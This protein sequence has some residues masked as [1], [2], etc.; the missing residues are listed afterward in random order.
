MSPW[1]WCTQVCASNFCLETPPTAVFLFYRL[2][3]HLS[4]AVPQSRYR[5]RTRSNAGG[6]EPTNCRSTLTHTLPLVCK[7]FHKLVSN[8]DVYWK[9]ALLRLMRKDPSLWKEGVR[10]V[11]FDHTCDY[12]NR[13]IVVREQRRVSE[14]RRDKRAR[15]DQIGDPES[16]S[17]ASSEPGNCAFSLP[18]CSTNEEFLD[19]ACRIIE[20]DPETTPLPKTRLLY[21]TVYISVLC[22]HVR[23]KG[24]VFY[25]DSEIELGESYGLHLFE[26]RYR[27]LIS[28]VM[29]HYPLAAR[30][31]GR[32]LPV[33]PGIFPPEQGRVMDDDL[34]ATTLSLL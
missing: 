7:H 17:S 14:R 30:R 13:E 19:Q 18:N 20:S 31:G 2:L 5:T 33:L 6:G 11:I 34:K 8:H 4:H 15:N 12:I 23:Y 1:K 28:E 25:M 3:L 9:D 26:P 32:V 21:Q 22:R 10:H 27:I 24:L 29:S 16:K